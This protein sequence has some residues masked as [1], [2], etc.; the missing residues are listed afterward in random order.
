MLGSR[1]GGDDDASADE[2]TVDGP[3][4]GGDTGEPEAGTGYAASSGVRAA[5]EDSDGAG[6][7]VEE[8]FGTGVGGRCCVVNVGQR[9]AGDEG[10]RSVGDDFAGGGGI[11]D[12][13]EKLI[14][15]SDDGGWKRCSAASGGGPDTESARLV[16][17]ESTR[18]GKRDDVANL[19]ALRRRRGARTSCVEEHRVE[20]SIVT[21]A[22]WMTVED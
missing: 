19:V 11:R 15:E 1:G 20:R 21:N 14:V 16:G 2:D 22:D 7:V 4:R 8:A 9:R 10:C 18:S 13:A 6:G 12:R 3:Q 5:E 17:E